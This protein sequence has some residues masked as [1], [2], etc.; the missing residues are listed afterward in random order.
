MKGSKQAPGSTKV[1]SD[2]TKAPGDAENTNE[3][4]SRSRPVKKPIPTPRS[5]EASINIR[6]Y[7]LFILNISRSRSKTPSRENQES[8]KL[9]LKSTNDVSSGSS[10]FHDNMETNDKI[11]VSRSRDGT[12]LEMESS[13]GDSYEKDRLWDEKSAMESVRSLSQVCF[14]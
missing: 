13:G 9:S 2:D 14:L 10:S 3:E 5:V 12:D 4:R 7:D 11:Q 6:D 8:P 1:K